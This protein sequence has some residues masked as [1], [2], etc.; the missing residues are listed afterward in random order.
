MLDGISSDAGLLLQAASAIRRS[1]ES[2]EPEQVTVNALLAE[3]IEIMTSER[4]IEGR[5]LIK[6]DF[7]ENLPTV[8]VD[9]SSLRDVLFV[10]IQNAV[11]AIPE[12]GTLT[13]SSKESLVDG[14]SRVDIA[15]TDTGVGIPADALPRIFDL[16]YTTK[17][18]GLGFGL[19]RAK[20]HIKS[21]GGDIAIESKAGEGTTFIIGLPAGKE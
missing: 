1:T 5:I 7:S 3:V 4:N 10:V 11:E 6:K 14:K 19:W 2:R 16:F 17:K 13:V 15:I 9:V 18:G 12:I 21:M 8:Y 20:M